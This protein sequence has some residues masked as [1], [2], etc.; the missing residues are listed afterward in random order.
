MFEQVFAHLMSLLNP[1]RHPGGATIVFNGSVTAPTDSPSPDPAPDP[2]PDEASL[3]PAAH[4]RLI[5]S[6]EALD[7]G[8]W[9]EP[10]QLP[11]W[12]RAHVAA[13]LALN[14]EGLAGALRGV[15]SGDAVPMYASQEDRDRDIDDLAG[16]PPAVIGERVAASAAEFEAAVAALTVDLRSTRIERT[17]GGMTFSAGKVARMRL[18]EV[19]IHHADL[20]VGYSAADWSPEV[21]AIVVEDG[22]R[23]TGDFTVRATDTGREWTAGG[24]GPVVSGPQ[25]ELAWWLTG[26][27][28]R[29]LSCSAGSLPEVGGW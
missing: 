7:G 2:A 11:G 14:A 9:S 24:G 28:P 12:T 5:R 1:P 25:S 16:Q 10:T 20:Q 27:T 21:S 8:A 19:E 18:R 29:G 13:H 17:P 26:R 3:L 22:V 15:V 6:I 23:Q 4:Q